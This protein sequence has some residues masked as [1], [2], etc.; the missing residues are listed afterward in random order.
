MVGSRR[1]SSRIARLVLS[2]VAAGLAFCPLLWALSSGLRPSSD[3]FRYLSPLRVWAFIPNRLTLHNVTGIW[4]TPFALAMLNSILVTG[5]TV[6]GG[7]ALCAPAAFALARLRV[8]F[9][10]LVFGLVVVSFLIPFDAISIPLATLFRGFGFENTYAGLVLP[11]LGN[12]FAVFLLR[13]FFAAIPIELSEAG[14]MDGLGWFGIFTRIYLPL[15][16][17]ALI[18]A[19][20]ILFIFQWQAFLWPLLIA[21]DPSYKV[22][23]VAI[24]DFAGEYS[25]DYGMI[26]TAAILVAVVPLLI[27]LIFQ[28][29]FT[30]SISATGGK[31]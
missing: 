21:P 4:S 8:P 6:L 27:L 15:S 5:L 29:N 14:R 2:A 17:P 28:R 1:I 9:G 12:G 30:G 10:S 22:A 16:R 3:I 26:F 31:E 7:L 18:G 11:G 13:Q 25:V 23:A 24:A 19:G 20:L